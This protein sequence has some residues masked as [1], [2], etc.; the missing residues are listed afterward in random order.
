[1]ISMRINRR[2]FLAL[3]VAG[4]GATLLDACGSAAAPAPAATATA[5]A[6][7][8]ATGSKLDDVV[9]QANSEGQVT[10]WIDQPQFDDTLAA[11]E[12]AFNKKFGTSIK[13]QQQRGVSGGQAISKIIAEAQ[14]N[15]HSTDF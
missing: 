10:M 1:M 14:G 4:A 12:S 9:K 3:S 13:I 6:K 8:S 15:V 2:R 7:P 11:A 5:A